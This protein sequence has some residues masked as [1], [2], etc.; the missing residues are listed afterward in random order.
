MEKMLQNP[1]KVGLL[2][3][4]TASSHHWDP[5]RKKLPCLL[6]I[7]AKKR[8]DPPLPAGLVILNGGGL[9]TSNGK[10]LQVVGLNSGF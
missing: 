1:K 3:H 8:S 2:T 10:S 6:G 5:K 9:V 7:R 4:Q